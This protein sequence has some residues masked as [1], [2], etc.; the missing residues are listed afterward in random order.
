MIKTIRAR[1]GVDTKN[2]HGLTLI[3]VI[4]ALMVFGIVAMGIAYS[5][6]SILALTRDS[7]SI[8]AATNLAAQVID[9]AR[10]SEDVFTVVDNDY[11][12]TVD[13]IDYYVKVRTGWVTSTNASA[14]C[15]ASGTSTTNGSLDFKRVNV[16][17]TWKGMRS[18]AK[19]VRS[20][21]LISPNSRINDPN[22]GTILVTVLTA[23]GTGSAGIKV[24]ATKNSE[25]GN[26]AV[27]P[28][29]QPLNTDNQGCSYILKVAPGKYDV[30]IE[31]SGYVDVDQNVGSV[32]RLVEV[33]KGQAAS[34]GFQF[35]APGLINPQ[36]AP[37]ASPA[38]LL[39]SNLKTTYVSTYGLVLKDKG[40]VGLHPFASGYQVFAGSFVGPTT[41][42]PAGCQ[43]PDPAAWT[44][45][46]ADGAI[47][48]REFPV[49]PVAGVPTATVAPVPM[50]IVS[51]ANMKDKYVTATSLEVGP[52]GS[53]DPGCG[54]DYVLNFPMITNNGATSLALPF[55]TWKLTYG[56]TVANSTGTAVNATLLSSLGQAI[57]VLPASTITIDPRKVVG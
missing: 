39:A 22:L 56:T 28:A 14:Q 12:T 35:D 16:A 30:K 41:T 18:V 19:P 33:K 6:G 32:T 9:T 44:T 45:A 13:S 49:I 43:S 55:G 34:V 57:G 1:L 27:T 53:G 52:A 2:E 37:G 46:R 21:T 54:V 3:E 17:V 4:V 36:Y 50:G 42:K 5:L 31:R 10:A 11:T 25:S 51:V 7:R 20:D 23:T 26:T 15:G 40:Q 47:G 48:I 38:P 8:A 29:V 24:T